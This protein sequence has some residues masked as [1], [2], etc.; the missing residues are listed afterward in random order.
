MTHAVRIHET[1]G[2]EAL[3][4]ETVEVGDPGPGEVRLILK[5]L[6]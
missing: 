3:R 4:Y 1:G 5:Q 2:P 6:P